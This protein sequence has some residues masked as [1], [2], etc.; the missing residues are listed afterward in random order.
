MYP[1]INPYETLTLRQFNIDKIVSGLR[2]A[3]A[4]GQTT[5]A[6]VKGFSHVTTLFDKHSDVPTFGHPIIVDGQVFVDVRG[7]VGVSPDR[8]VRVKDKAEYQFRVLRAALELEWNKDEDFRDQLV[9][10]SDLPL[11]IY[12]KWFS[13]GITRRLGLGPETQAKLTAVAGFYYLQCVEGEVNER[14]WQRNV[15][16]VARVTR[17]PAARL[18]EMFPEPLSF[19]S[20]T[21]LTMYISEHLDDPRLG[22]MNNTLLYG[23]LANGWYTQ[24]GNEVMGVALEMP[25]TWIACVYHAVGDRALR[26]STI[27]RLL[28]R[29]KTDQSQFQRAILSLLR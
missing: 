20:M 29:T 6:D 13:E 11:E 26:N 10:I 16:I 7:I 24:H 8:Q 18:V 25:I 21:E 9:S 12:T 2:V 28:Q 3:N 15:A 4:E 22:K 17:I 1:Y 19:H 23:I 27:G 5:H 14:V